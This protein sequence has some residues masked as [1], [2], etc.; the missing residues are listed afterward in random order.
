MQH[1]SGRSVMLC[2]GAGVALAVVGA[3][4]VWGIGNAPASDSGGG[5]VPVV[6]DEVPMRRQGSYESR[7]ETDVR[8]R[9]PGLMVDPDGGARLTA[10]EIRD[11][12]RMAFAPDVGMGV[13]VG[14]ALAWLGSDSWIRVMAATRLVL[15]Q[16]LE[17]E[18]DPEVG[19]IE[20]LTWGA[21]KARAF[22]NPVCVAVM[23]LNVRSNALS[24]SSEELFREL[25]AS[26][27]GAPWWPITCYLVWGLEMPR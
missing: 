9:L 1:G 13:L 5:R 20:V 27:W 7:Y 15:Y 14:Q 24:E 2:V 12:C 6:D 21:G 3:W 10:A 25:C 26:A 19:P 4:A 22:A 8:F 11:V 23:V 16:C 17:G 18:S